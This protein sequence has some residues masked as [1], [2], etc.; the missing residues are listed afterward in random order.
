MNKGYLDSAED[1]I[2]KTLAIKKRILEDYHIEIA[3]TMI[4]N[5]DD[6]NIN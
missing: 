4:S 6:Y 3:K 2:I 1:N 5:Y